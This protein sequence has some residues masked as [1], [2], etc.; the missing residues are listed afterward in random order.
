MKI[1]VPIVAE[2]TK[3]AV[4][5]IKKANSLADIIELRIDY[6]RPKPSEE[7]LRKL[8][9]ACAKPSIATNRKK[10]EGG[11]FAGSD[12]ERIALLKKAAELGA[13]F[14]DIEFSSGKK[15]KEIISNSKAKAILSYHNFENTPSLEELLELLEKMRALQPEI[16]KIVC[17]AQSKED[18]KKILALVEKAREKGTKIIAFCMGDAGKPSRIDSLKAGAFLG[19]ASLEKG[20]ES[21]AGQMSIKEMRNILEREND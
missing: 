1:A 15:A 17:F 10:E 16:V 20:K 18:N 2:T 9:S 12:G 13:E 11:K 5:Q 4:A 6:L 8:F 21:A 19:F 3:E 14:V 7:D